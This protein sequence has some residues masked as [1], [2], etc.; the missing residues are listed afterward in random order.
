MSRYMLQ[1]MLADTAYRY[2]SVFLRASS[3]MAL[4]AALKALSQVIGVST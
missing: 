4:N 1:S 2:Q 3:S